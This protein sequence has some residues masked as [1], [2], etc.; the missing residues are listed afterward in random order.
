ME[1]KML[2]IG[3]NNAK[4]AHVLANRYQKWLEKYYQ[5]Q[6]LPS[7]GFKSR[8]YIRQQ[9]DL[10]A[11]NHDSPDGGLPLSY[12]YICIYIYI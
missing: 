3:T 8:R 5:L 7:N 12:I 4:K 11:H 10:C 6:T 9:P 2:Q 1:V